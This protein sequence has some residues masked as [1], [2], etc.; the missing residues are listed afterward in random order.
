MMTTL[1]ILKHY[2][3]ASLSSPT[4]INAKKA[5]S[6]SNF[7]VYHVAHDLG[8]LAPEISISI[9]TSYCSSHQK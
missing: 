4:H 2:K 6:E 5:I 3:E 1:V 9:F 7:S 8:T